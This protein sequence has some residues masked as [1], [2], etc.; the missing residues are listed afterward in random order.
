MVSK[1]LTIGKFVPGVFGTKQCEEKLFS[2]VKEHTDE[3]ETIR[4]NIGTSF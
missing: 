4:F 3:T 2:L 1:L